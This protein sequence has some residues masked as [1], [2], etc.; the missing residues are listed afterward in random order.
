MSKIRLESFYGAGRTTYAKSVAFDFA[1]KRMLFSTIT[2]A[3]RWAEELIG[4]QPVKVPSRAT[5]KVVLRDAGI[6][7]SKVEFPNG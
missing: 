3:Q 2:D 6:D 1:G 4:K 7:Y 5:L